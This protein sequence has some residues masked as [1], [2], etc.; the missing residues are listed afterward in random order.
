M[1]RSSLA[2]H[3]KPPYRDSRAIERVA[4]NFSTVAS[5]RKALG[6]D[7]WPCTWAVDDN[8]Y[9][10]WGDGGGFDGN[11]D[12]IGRVSLGFARV[13]GVPVAGDPAAFHGKNIWGQVPYAQVQA[14]F[15][16]KI[17]SL[18]AVDGALYGVGGL[19]IASNA[20]IASHQS[21]QGPLRALVKSLDL[22]RSWSVVAASDELSRGSFL[23]FGRN[24]AGSIDAYIY[25]YYQRAGD[26]A[27]IYLKRIRKD[28]LASGTVAAKD[29]Q[30]LRRVNRHGHA[31]VWSARESDATPIFFDARN[32]TTPSVVYDAPL[33]RYLLTVGH[34]AS[35]R[36][37]DASPA[38]FGL[39]ESPH[40]WGPWATVGYYDH[41]ID[42]PARSAGDFL[43]VQIPSKWISADGKTF[44]AVFS[45]TGIYDSF[46]LVEGVLTARRPWWRSIQ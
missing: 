26:E 22:G 16:G 45:G 3:S 38:Q 25:L 35:G 36:Q 30:Y 46:N 18:I 42:I 27:H 43:G 11:S 17:S 23:N 1:P 12:Q 21:E 8:L 39:F 6:S 10:A 9:C 2:E 32:V 5:L 29:L 7:L 14:T 4:W 28:R 40:P 20:Y 44:W 24:N 37:T 15:G 19:W 41:W 34:Y 13:S 33:N 31:V